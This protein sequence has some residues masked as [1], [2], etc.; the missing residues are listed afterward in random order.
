MIL[1]SLRT[2]TPPDYSLRTSTDNLSKGGFILRIEKTLKFNSS[3]NHSYSGHY[4]EPSICPVCKHAIKPS[5][6]LLK[7]YSDNNGQWF[8][9]GFYLC[10]HCYHTFLTLHKCELFR[11]NGHPTQYNA[12]LL[13][14]EPTRY[15][16]EQFED[17]ISTLSPQ[18]VKIYNQA[19][20][21]ESSGLDEIAGLGYRKAMEFLIKD[22][23]IHLRPDDE[24]RIQSMPLAQCIKF[25]VESTQVQTLATCAAWI[26]NDEAHYI[27]K[28]EGRDV[29]DMKKFIK[30]A[31]YFIGMVLITEDASSMSPT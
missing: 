19:L 9:S 27:R 4:E 18:F 20:A 2:V 7:E 17:N 31:I 26:G 28:Q 21:A 25:Y 10:R 1:Q 5:E 8:L 11:T 14:V 12:E 29:S 3:G 22:F 6:I 24:E 15:V 13:P 16:E 30:A 23:C